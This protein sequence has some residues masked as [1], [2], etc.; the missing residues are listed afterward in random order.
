MT[1]PLPLPADELWKKIGDLRGMTVWDPA[2]ET[3]VLS[4][5]GRQRTVHIYGTAASNVG[6][7]R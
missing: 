1:F 6:E 4:A 7:Q 3:C 5:G 2:V